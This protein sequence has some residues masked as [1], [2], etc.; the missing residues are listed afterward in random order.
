MQNKTRYRYMYISS[1]K[2]YIKITNDKFKIVSSHRERSIKG[3]VMFYFLNIRSNMA[4]IKILR[5]PVFG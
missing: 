5:R 2:I 1:I 3:P 4:S